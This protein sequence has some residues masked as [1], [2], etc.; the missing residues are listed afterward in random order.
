MFSGKDYFIQQKQRAG[1]LFEKQHYVQT[2][3]KK[4]YK[5][6]ATSL[7]QAWNDGSVIIVFGQGDLRVKLACEL[8]RC[9]TNNAMSV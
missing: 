3:K 2:C 6:K 1:Q 4:K 9:E 8:N 7:Y 5:K